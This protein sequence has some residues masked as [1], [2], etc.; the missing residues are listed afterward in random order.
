MH[1]SFSLAGEVAAAR[2][3][4]RKSS[5]RMKISTLAGRV[6]KGPT[7]FYDMC[8]CDDATGISCEL[9]ELY[10]EGMVIKET[11][12]NRGYETEMDVMGVISVVTAL[13]VMCECVYLELSSVGVWV[14]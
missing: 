14:F 1:F 5:V 9:Y 3:C 10:M 6:S 12:V 4:A 8:G 13:K 11:D 2:G 7:L